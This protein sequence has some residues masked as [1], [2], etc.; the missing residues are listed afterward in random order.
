MSSG[1]LLGWLR[2]WCV[3][4]LAAT[5]FILSGCPFK[6]SPPPGYIRLFVDSSNTARCSDGIKA[7]LVGIQEGWLGPGYEHG[8][9]DYTYGEGNYWTW[10]KPGKIS[11]PMWRTLDGLNKNP[12]GKTITVRAYC[13]RTGGA[14]PGVSERS[15]DAGD[16]TAF[17]GGVVSRRFIVYDSGSD[18][19]YTVT[20]PGLTIEDQ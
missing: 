4:A 12:T 3:V 15:F 6:N 16:L 13:M 5:V 20:P 18:P 2:W 19:D 9:D 8:E 14:E 11:T 10:V 1:K 7:E 17:G